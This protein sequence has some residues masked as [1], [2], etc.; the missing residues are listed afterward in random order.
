MWFEPG[1]FKL[2]VA[3]WDKVGRTKSFQW[4]THTHTVIGLHNIPILITNCY[5]PSA[6]FES[7]LRP[8]FKTCL[9]CFE[10]RARTS[11]NNSEGLR[12]TSLLK[13]LVRIIN[14][15]KLAHF[16]M[17]YSAWDCIHRNILM[18]WK[19]FQV[20]YVHSFLL[21]V[22]TRHCFRFF[23]C[24]CLPTTTKEMVCKKHFTCRGE[25]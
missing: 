4:H 8:W 24:I 18:L 5:I 13:G 20:G 2:W 16:T 14:E 10:A 22:W 6:I 11:C 9:A 21:S 23:I 1:V 25:R 17:L 3:E 7:Q 19:L 15:K 12:A